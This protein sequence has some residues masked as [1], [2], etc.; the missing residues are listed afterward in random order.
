LGLTQQSCDPSDT[1]CHSPNLALG[2][3]HWRVTQSM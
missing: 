1:E 3:D 2:R